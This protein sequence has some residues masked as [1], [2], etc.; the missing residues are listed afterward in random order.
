[1][2]DAM[3]CGDNAA[4]NVGKLLREVSRILRPNA[5]FLVLS[6]APPENRMGLLQNASY[7]WTVSSVAV[8]KPTVGGTQAASLPASADIGGGSVHHLYVCVRGGRK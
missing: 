6:S 3:M 5:V 8:A 2:I 7:G 1:M 4:E